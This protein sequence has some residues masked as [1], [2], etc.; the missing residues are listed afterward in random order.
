MLKCLAT[1]FALV[2]PQLVVMVQRVVDGV[3]GVINIIID[4]VIDTWGA[5]VADG[6]NITIN[7]C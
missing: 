2:G 6:S 1:F 5:A 3:A 4:I 7:I